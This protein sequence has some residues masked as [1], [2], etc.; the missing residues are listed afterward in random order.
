[1]G[2]HESFG[3]RV[4]RLVV[5]RVAY[6]L[7]EN[8]DAIA[9]LKELGVVDESWLGDPEADPLAPLFRLRAAANRISEQPSLLQGTNIKT[10]ELLGAQSEV[11]ADASSG[12]EGAAL[13][14]VFT[15][16]EGFT[17]YTEDAGDAVASRLLRTHYDVVDEIVL[18][19][20]GEVVKRLGDGHMATFTTAR[21]AVLATLELVSAA[22]DDLRLRAGGHLGSVVRL[23]GDVVGHT[24]N[25]AS[26]VAGSA[27]GGH[28]RVTLPVR[29]EAGAVPGIRYGDPIEERFR[30]IDEDVAVCDVARS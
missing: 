15:D 5:R 25:L 29:D 22:P 19:R 26:R 9:K 12:S 18:G 30:G 8:P 14:V 2:G 7:Q 20:G 23:G 16:L 17:S 10:I 4:K 1:M 6:L 11:A 13:T 28:V 27:T 21:A 24:V 3:D